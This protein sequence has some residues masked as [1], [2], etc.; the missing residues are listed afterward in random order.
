MRIREAKWHGFIKKVLKE[1]GEKYEFDVSESEKEMYF[2]V[3]Y[4]LFDGVHAE[5]HI[6][7]YKPD[8]VWKKGMQ[9]HTIFE[10][11]YLNPKSQVLDKRK[12]VLGT[13]LLGLT[14]LC[15]KSC[16]NLVLITNKKTLCEDVGTCY[17]ILRQKKILSEGFFK[18]RYVLWYCLDRSIYEKFR[19]PT[20]QERWMKKM[21]PE[22]F[23][24]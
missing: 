7:T 17:E 9:Y 6:L 12:Y 16:R 24:L 1:I 19:D 10:I 2:P 5:K 15:E 4:R 23:R 14:A 20:F 21:L 3:K 11:E 13:F 22:N 18:G 8:V